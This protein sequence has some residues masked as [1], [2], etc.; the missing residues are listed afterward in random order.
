MKNPKFDSTKI[1]YKMYK[2]GKRWVFAGIITTSSYFLMSTTSAFAEVDNGN[3]NNGKP[4]TTVINDSQKSDSSPN[5]DVKQTNDDAQKPVKPAENNDATPKQEE[6]AG[7]PEKGSSTS[8][9]HSEKPKENNPDQYIDQNQQDLLKQSNQGKEDSPNGDTGSKTDDK[10]K[11]Q[12]TESGQSDPKQPAQPAKPEAEKTDDASKQAGPQLAQTRMPDENGLLDRAGFSQVNSAKHE[13][14]ENPTE[15]PVV[16]LLETGK[17][18]LLGKGVDS[19]YRLV[20][21]TIDDHFKDS[22]TTEF[23]NDSAST[24]G[25][26]FHLL[27]PAT[28]DE[29]G[30]ELHAPVYTNTNYKVEFKFKVN[31]G[32][33]NFIN[34]VKGFGIQEQQ[35]TVVSN[36]NNY[37]TQYLSFTSATNDNDFQ[38]KP[39]LSLDIGAYFYRPGNWNSKIDVNIESV[40]LIPETPHIVAKPQTITFNL[41]EVKNQTKQQILDKYKGEIS[42]ILKTAAQD[43]ANNNNPVLSSLNPVSESDEKVNDIFGGF[44]VGYTAAKWGQKAAGTINIE[45]NDD[46]IVGQRKDAKEEIKK[47]RSTAQTTL[48]SFK[49]ISSDKLNYYRQQIEQYAKKGDSAVDVANTKVRVDESKEDTLRNINSLTDLL[50]AINKANNDIDDKAEK[51]KQTIDSQSFLDKTDKSQSTTDV[52]NVVKDTKNNISN[53]QSKTSVDSAKSD[54]SKKIDEILEKVLFKNTKE[55]EK[56]NLMNKSDKI[57]KAIKELP[58]INYDENQLKSDLDKIVSS[59][60]DNIDNSN[61]NNIKSKIDENNQNLESFFTNQKN[62]SKANIDNAFQ[63]SQGEIG[64][65]RDNKIK[66]I[67]DDPN[68]TDA[69]KEFFRNKLIAAADNGNKKIAQG[70]TFKQISDSEVEVYG[71]L[72]KINN[73][74]LLQADKNQKVKSSLDYQKQVNGEIDKLSGLTRSEKDNIKRKIKEVVDKSIQDINNSQTQIEAG[75]IFDKN[76]NQRYDNTIKKIKDEN[77]HK[78]NEV[79]SQAETTLGEKVTTANNRINGMSGLTEQQKNN[80]KNS[81]G[82][83]NT[84]GKTAIESGDK[85]ELDQKLNDAETAIQNIVKEQADTNQR[86]LQLKR[87]KIP[88]L[89]KILLIVLKQTLITI[90]P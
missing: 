13:Y 89:Y 87:K 49:N 69:E 6:T 44:S 32:S 50:T 64:T 58:G 27:A 19:N 22:Y 10:P 48:D 82:Q 45:I 70:A 7:Q 74:A 52:D 34:G 60:K 51:A 80:A 26:A 77:T 16:H 42:E 61:E 47:A 62:I 28:N 29:G 68:L 67:N 11:T 12:T 24:T 3:A 79:V 31:S 17:N 53:A 37:Q 43:S 81:I 56:N 35:H 55:S 66:S 20:A 90:K 36:D 2:S 75:E 5:L 9:T 14:E 39:N 33:G 40:S 73:D 72:N 4:I 25:K 57:R 65:D 71:D 78:S 38:K 84:K 46:M 8:D 21:F 85:D 41:S 54:G 76:I 18:N 1:R 15:L 30:M 59:G 86:Q 83:E 88:V 63:R 23:V